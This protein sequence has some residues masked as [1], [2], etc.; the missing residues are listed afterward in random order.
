MNGALAAVGELSWDDPF[1]GRKAR[2]ILGRARAVELVRIAADFGH[3]LLYA[4]M[5]CN[6]VELA[7]YLVEELGLGDEVRVPDALGAGIADFKDAAVDVVEFLVTSGRPSFSSR[8]RN[9]EGIGPLFF[10]CR[11][12]CLQIV[13][14]LIGLGAPL[15]D[16]FYSAEGRETCP[17]IGA[18]EFWHHDCLRELLK[19]GADP[20]IIVDRPD[21]NG[22]I[23]LLLMATTNGRPVAISLVLRA[24]AS[25]GKDDSLELGRALCMAV[26]DRRSRIIL[27]MLLNAGASVYS[28]IGGRD[29]GKFKDTTPFYRAA[30]S[31]RTGAAR[32]FFGRFGS[33]ILQE[34]VH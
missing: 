11:N 23:S 5:K 20:H 31:G 33:G 32:Y 1:L 30:K 34:D 19:S 4:A 2:E 17:A 29:E 25:R 10:A 9:S 28:T 24:M 18:V 8:S 16:R 21:L 6:D 15:N 3:D 12:G 14:L 27:D 7:R 26:T 22:K 13:K